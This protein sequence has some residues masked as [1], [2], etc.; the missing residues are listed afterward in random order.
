MRDEL[1]QQLYDSIQNENEV[2]VKQ[3]DY[4][5]F[6]SWSNMK[7][8]CNNPNVPCYSYYGGKGIKVCNRWNSFESFLED[9]GERPEGMT[10]D[11]IDSNK[12]YEPTNCRWATRL[13]QSQN[14]S[15]GKT[16]GIRKLPSGNYQVRVKQNSVGVFKNI[17]EAI[18]VRSSY[19]A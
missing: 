18:L 11:R 17:K 12:D 13:T 19:G 2:R 5:A 7:S 3:K 6:S 4:R 15:F 14:R 9:M 10:L 1:A 16:V 8:R